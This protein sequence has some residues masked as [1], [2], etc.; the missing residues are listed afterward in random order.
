MTILGIDCGF[1]LPGAAVL[2]DNQL[3][4]VCALKTKPMSK[5]ERKKTSTYKSDDDA[6]RVAEISDWLA[7]LVWEFTPAHVVVELPSS[8][9]KSAGGIRGMALGS[10]TTVAT[11]TRL[12]YVVGKTLH[13]ITPGKNKVGS[14]GEY[15]AEKEQVLTAVRKKFPAF[16]GFDAMPAKKS[17]RLK[18]KPDPDQ[19]FAAADAASAVVA[20]GRAPLCFSG[21]DPETIIK[22]NDGRWARRCSRG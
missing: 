15:H 17:G 11:F 21:A 20:A 1:S 10:A 9:A 7:K 16:A 14:T 8:G 3:C 22:N 18:G 19:Q 5:K 13:F 4:Y 12:N 6:R 2:T